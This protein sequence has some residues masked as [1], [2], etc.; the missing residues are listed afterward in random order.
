ME[1]DLVAAKFEMDEL[2]SKITSSMAP[3]GSSNHAA[4]RDPRVPE[5][6]KPNLGRRLAV[7]LLV[8]G[9]VESNPKTLVA[10][11]AANAALN[12]AAKGKALAPDIDIPANVKRVTRP[13][14]GSSRLSS[15]TCAANS[16]PADTTGESS[17]GPS[18]PASAAEAAPALRSSRSA[19][20]AVVA[21]KQRAARPSAS[22]IF[23]ASSVVCERQAAIALSLESSSS[24]DSNNSTACEK[25]SQD[26]PMDEFF[27]IMEQFVEEPE[28]MEYLRASEA[29]RR[30][31]KGASG[32]NGAVAVSGRQLAHQKSQNK[33][34][35]RQPS[36]Q[37]A[38]AAA[39]L[40]AQAPV[41]RHHQRQKSFAGVSSPAERNPSTSGPGANPAHSGTFELNPALQAQ[42]RAAA[43]S[44]THHSRRPSRVGDMLDSAP[45]LSMRET[46]VTVTCNGNRRSSHP[47]SRERSRSFCDR[48]TT[49]EP[50]EARLAAANTATACRPA[51]ATFSRSDSFAVGTNVSNS[52]T[53]AASREQREQQREADASQQ[54]ELE[55]LVDALKAEIRAKD[56]L[57]GA[58]EGERKLLEEELRGA[59]EHVADLER[60]LEG[61]QA[62]GAAME[63][64]ID[65]L[66]AQV[67]KRSPGQRRGGSDGD[68][69]VGNHI[70]EMERTLAELSRKLAATEGALQRSEA[71]KAELSG[72][73]A[74]REDELGRTKSALQQAELERDSLADEMEAAL[75]SWAADSPRMSPP[76]AGPSAAAGESQKQEAA[77]LVNALEA[78][79]RELQAVQAERNSLLMAVGQPRRPEL[80]SAAS[81]PQSH[82]SGSRT[83][84][85]SLTPPPT[86][87]RGSSLS[88]SS[89]SGPMELQRNFGMEASP[90][91]MTTQQRGRHVHFSPRSAD[92]K[93]S[94]N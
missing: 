68:R 18:K 88:T 44:Q 74:V 85:R 72:K 4:S 25:P 35:A 45:S 29:A 70:L 11:A 21:R 36:F 94:A 83:S 57:L 60:Q 43:P 82:H 58:S 71:Q 28:E 81:R 23:R 55:S 52:A 92:V 30:N 90:P 5:T 66:R 9:D 64:E 15:V 54:R 80:R 34:F 2:Y 3:S 16:A 8:G 78:A 89:R 40:S 59:W 77:I 42:Q 69:A 87:T 20:H 37:E 38:P 86:H 33:E 41:M 22:S 73:V 47:M 91:Q 24:I 39:P 63:R 53:S 67:N 79:Q 27:A 76:A 17:A 32:A 1:A 14:V 26:D 49:V 46:P 13:P 93:V 48:V 10:A 51:P 6:G 31:R 50:E 61:M 75:A 12:A 84:N 7:R 62:A 56:Q 65:S 19:Q